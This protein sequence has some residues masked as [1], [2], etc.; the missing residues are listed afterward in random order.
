MFANLMPAAKDEAIRL[1][2][3]NNH[4]A[5]K[6]AAA[7][8]SVALQIKALNS[9]VRQIAAK[10]E[11]KRLAQMTVREQA[12]AAIGAEPRLLAMHDHAREVTTAYWLWLIE[13]FGERGYQVV[14]RLREVDLRL[15]LEIAD[16]AKAEGAVPKPRLH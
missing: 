11:R 16:N 7:H 8:D 3:A 5:L 1:G 12:A 13:E 14:N 15:L 2:I 6:Y 4:H 10:A 9:Q